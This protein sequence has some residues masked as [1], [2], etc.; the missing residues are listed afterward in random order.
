MR[1]TVAQIAEMIGGTV[2]GDGSAVIEGAAGLAEATEKDISFLGNAKYTSHLK[3]TRAGALLV[4]ADIQTDGKP[5]IVLK[6]PPYGWAKVLE[7]LSKER[8]QH[9]APGIHPTAVVAKSAKIGA[10][11][12]LG[13]YCV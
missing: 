2:R 9:P 7:I 3:T 1:L 8:L 13:A 10:N 4:P 12:S 6:N 5:A 11:V